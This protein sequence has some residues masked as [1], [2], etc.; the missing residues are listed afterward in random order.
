MEVH[1]VECYGTEGGAPPPPP[2]SR[3]SAPC[4]TPRPAPHH[5]S[6]ITWS[7]EI[8]AFRRQFAGLRRAAEGAPRPRGGGGDGHIG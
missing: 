5:P 1:P 6:P 2:A 3:H 8:S 7:A 4:L